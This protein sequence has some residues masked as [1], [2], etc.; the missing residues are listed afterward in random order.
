MN[1]DDQQF[2]YIGE[3]GFRFDKGR[4]PESLLRDLSRLDL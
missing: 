1:V 2:K 3:T 4:H